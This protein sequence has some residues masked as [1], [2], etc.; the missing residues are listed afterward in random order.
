MSD[1]KPALHVEVWLD[2]TSLPLVHEAVSTYTKGPFYC[3]MTQADGRSR[4]YK[5]P[6]ARVFRVIEE[7]L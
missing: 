2:E 3:V 7:A 4:F 1:K 5:Y 6:V